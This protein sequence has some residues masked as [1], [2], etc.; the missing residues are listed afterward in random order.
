MPSWQPMLVVPLVLGLAVGCT[1]SAYT[2]RVRGSSESD[3]EASARADR[4]VASYRR[5]L[6]PATDPAATARVDHVAGALVDA[7]KAGPAS[8]RASAV[9]WEFS[10][11]DSPETTIASFAN[12]TI[13]VHS[14]IV[15]ALPTDDALA[16]MLGHAVAR[17][18]LGHDAE[19]ASRR[20]AGH[21]LPAL[22]EMGVSVSGG[23]RSEIEARQDEEADWVGLVLAVDAGYDPD[24][25]AEAFDR[26]GLR[27]RGDAVRKRLPEL[28]A[29]AAENATPRPPRP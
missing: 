23:S 5:G 26:L 14:G 20:R 6:R 9:T 29:H 15:R 27:D 11:V 10:V 21:A 3:D 18:L 25:A 1:R 16:A 17:V 22:A 4:A 12:G 8:A 28:R 24:R 19:L 7:A 13:V 2:G